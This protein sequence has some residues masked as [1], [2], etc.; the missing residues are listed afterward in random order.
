MTTKTDSATKTDTTTH[1]TAA[2]ATGGW[3]RPAPTAGAAELKKWAAQRAAALRRTRAKD[4][5]R[6]LAVAL[7][8]AGVPAPAG[9]PFW[10]RL[11]VTSSLGPIA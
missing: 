2:A 1:T 6:S 10:T 3:V 4:I 9:E 8:K 7:N 11:L 5:A